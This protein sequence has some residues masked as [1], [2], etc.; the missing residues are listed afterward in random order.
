MMKVTDLARRIARAVRELHYAQRRFSVLITA[1][2]R[3]LPAKDAS[4]C[5]YAEFL[6]RTSGFLLH[7]PSAADRAHGQLVG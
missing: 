3:H 6:Y 2:D 1:P 5:T 7:E 4:P